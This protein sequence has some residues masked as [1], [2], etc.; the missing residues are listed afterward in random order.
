MHLPVPDGT[1]RCADCRQVKVLAEFPRHPTNV[2]G[3]NCYCKACHNQRGRARHFQRSYG[4]TAQDVESLGRA[5]G[6]VCAVCRGRRAEHVDHDHV[7]G[8]VRG[9]LCFSCN[10]ALGQFRDDIAT[11]QRAIDYLRRTT[12]QRV[13]VSPGVVRLDPPQPARADTTYAPPGLD[14]LIA[15][16]RG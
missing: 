15:S 3:Y 8:I 13:T 7:T 9:L 14:E 4:M 2:S 16:R 10:A 5:Q 12:Y 6:G 1:R 11:L